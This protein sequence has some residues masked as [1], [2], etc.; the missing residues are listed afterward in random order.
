MHAASLGLHTCKHITHHC[1][2]RFVSLPPSSN[3]QKQLS[4]VF[5]N[6]CSYWLHILQ[7]HVLQCVCLWH[8]KSK[9]SYSD[10]HH[11]KSTELF[12]PEAMFS[13]GLIY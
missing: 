8:N 7:A 12:H 9:H 11:K 6:F 10:N 5:L 13:S 2:V 3:W 1:A 4:K